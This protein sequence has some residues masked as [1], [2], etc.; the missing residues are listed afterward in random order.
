MRSIPLR[1]SDVYSLKVAK[2]R[3]ND[4]LLLLLMARRLR[5]ARTRRAGRSPLRV[6]VVTVLVLGFATLA[7]AAVAAGKAVQA[8]LND[9]SLAGRTAKPLPATSFVYARRGY[10]LGTVPAVS[11][12]QPVGYD[13]MSPWIRQATVAAEDRTFWTNDGLDF[14]SIARA[15]LADLAAGRA[16]QGA[17]T[18][19]QQLVRNL[20]LNDDKTFA[21]KRLEACL[22][23]K[24]TKEWTRRRI[25]TSYLNRIPYGSH[26]LGIEAA[27]ETY[28]GVPASR[29][30][31][32]QAAFLA[33]LPQAPS[34]YDPFAHPQAAL[35]RRN[36][37]LE[38]MLENGALSGPDCRRLIRRPLGLHPGR[39]YRLERMPNF[40]A[41][42]E[43]QLVRAY[44][45]KEVQG[46]GLRVYTTLDPRAERLALSTMRRTLDRR[47][48]PASALVSIDPH[49]GAIR[50]LASNWHGHE[51][52]Y[53]LPADGARQT[54]SA[55]KTFVLT[56]AVW[57]HRADPYT[58]WYDS[59]KFTYRST[60]QAKPWT[61]RTYEGTYFGPETLLKATLR[62]DNVVYAK[63]TLDLGPGSVARVAHQMGITSPLQV[64]PS[65]GLGSNS[66][67]PLVLA[68]A[69]ATLASGGVYHRPYAIWKV[70]LP[71]GRP[72]GGHR[73]GTTRAHRVLPTGVAWTVTKVLEAN[74]RAGTGVAAQIPGRHVAGKTGTT[75][76]W[77]DAWFAGYVPRLTT[78]TWV[79]YPL[80]PR[81]MSDVH[82]IQVQGATFP[83]EIWHGFMARTLAGSP[84]GSFP[85]GG[86]RLRPYHGRR[87]MHRRPHRAHRRRG[88]RR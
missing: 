46:G 78:V 72:A 33:G 65:I 81:S 63:L 77:T 69:Y 45:R 41:Y 59:S 39:L 25:L 64:V 35:D 80:H 79:G 53:D 34:A 84:A 62:S 22:A 71:D 9:C 14:A 24:L 56:D 26:A 49:S 37:V 19:T 3:K 50:A 57:H 36:Q 82:G 23:L 42:V 47:G 6:V 2:R 8:A 21:R 44:G 10:L 16:V 18:I 76:R 66:V 40:F 88:R 87:S 61:P 55:F 28:F 17:S 67:T 48:D 29:L 83:A 74:V 20:Y 85:R 43:A 27:A 60:P 12:R 13:A 70:E 31:P 15:A 30:G 52:Q 86:W 75:T 7:G 32:D 4:A 51:L 38:A 5:R 11:H 54:G 58:T 73:W 68:S 1:R